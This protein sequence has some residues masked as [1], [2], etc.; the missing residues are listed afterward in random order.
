ME[1]EAQIKLEMRLCALEYML[2]KIALM[3]LMRFVPLPDLPNHLDQLAA[4]AA[5]QVFSGLDPA[6]SDLASAEWHLAIE[7]LVNMQKE[8]LAAALA[9]P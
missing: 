2:S 8:M 3:T 5:T 1:S 4:D 7:Q 9:K 6:Q